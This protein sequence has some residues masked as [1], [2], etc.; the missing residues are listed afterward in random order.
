MA[1]DETLMVSEERR[2]PTM[3]CGHPHAAQLGGRPL[4]YA[5]PH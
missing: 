1:A 4:A 5:K 2:T 3:L